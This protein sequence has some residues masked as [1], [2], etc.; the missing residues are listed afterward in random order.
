[1]PLTRTSRDH[2]AAA[3][4]AC[5]WE[6]LKA[7]PSH[8]ESLLATV[9]HSEPLYASACPRICPIKLSCRPSVTLGR[10][11][12]SGQAFS[13]GEQNGGAFRRAMPAQA[14]SWLEEGS[15]SP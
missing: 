1:M 5:T 8:C 7:P 4:A 15:R 12:M 3:A 11:L 2:P 10:T 14:T 6:A 13:L 9:R